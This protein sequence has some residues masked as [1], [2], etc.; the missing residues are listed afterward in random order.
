[1]TKKTL[2]EAVRR[3]HEQASGLDAWAGEAHGEK[4][5]AALDAA[6]RGVP[7]AEI[8]SACRVARKTVYRWLKE[9]QREEQ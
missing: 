2:L 7:V 9:A 5:S 6:R 3:R 1:M 8:A 4:R